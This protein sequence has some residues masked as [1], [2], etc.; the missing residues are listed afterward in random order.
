MD[1][2]RFENNLAKEQ[3]KIL[4]R[5]KD[6]NIKSVATSNK[7]FNSRDLSDGKGKFTALLEQSPNS[8]NI[9]E[10]MNDCSEKTNSHGVQDY[11]TM[12]NP[13]PLSPPNLNKTKGNRGV[14]DM[15]KA[16][17][18]EYKKEFNNPAFN[19]QLEDM[20]R[21]QQENH[22]FH[23]IQPNPL[24]NNPFSGITDG[25]YDKSRNNEAYKSQH[26]NQYPSLPAN[27]I[28]NSKQYYQDDQFGRYKTV[29]ENDTNNLGKNPIPFAISNQSTTSI[30][31]IN[32][33][34]PCVE[35]QHESNQQIK[36]GK[37][38]FFFAV[39]QKN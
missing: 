21:I 9:Y 37:S 5:A 8:H 17:T 15:Y 34:N 35:P 24:S 12:K 16:D 39:L 14:P 1:K 18:T 2:E 36:Q 27:N 19:K 28:Q 6:N 30:V 25:I 22:Q 4:K 38:N 11:E 33:P 20:Q 26:F 7:D 29:A 13:S 10:T 23:S 32:Q 3:E 31:K